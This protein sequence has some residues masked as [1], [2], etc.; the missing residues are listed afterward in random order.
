MNRFAMSFVVALVAA[1]VSGAAGAQNARIITFQD[2]VRIALE[3][4]PDV[5]QAQNAAALGKVNVSEARNQ[6]LPD[7]RFSSTGAKNYGRTFDQT[8]GAIVNQSTRSLS[9]G[10][11]SSVTVFDGFGNVANLRGARLSD[12]AGEQEL[13]RTRETV[14]FNVASQFLALIQRQEQLRVQRENLQ[15]ATA[16]E[17]QIQQYVDAGARTIADLYQ[18]QANAASARFAVVDAERTSELAKVDLME[19]LQLDPTGTYEFEAP[20]D[21]TAAAA[22]QRFELA[23]LQTRAAAQRIDL[24]AEQARVEAADQNVKVARSNRWPTVSL[25]GGY[26]SAYSSASPFDLSDQLDQRRGGS[27]SLGVSVPIFDRSVTSNATR[28]AEIQADN[29][30]LAFESLQQN[31]ALQ[32]RRAHLD[33]QSAQEQLVN[34]QAQVKSAELSLSASQDRYDAGASTLL[35]VTQARA[36]QVQAAS[37][38]VSA[39]Y[40]LQFQRTLMDYY[41]GDLDPKQLSGN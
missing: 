4:N 13:T 14:A 36:T 26:S 7:L 11:N 25:N 10:V 3:Q 34:A 5:R 30:R 28:R 31:V 40:N 21:N 19:T 32:V 9:L 6:F 35:E 39:R 33:F 24:R 41:V 2:A 18:Q 8:E 15:A 16:L 12:Q 27:V 37:A 17:Q 23:N 29:E 1:A 20:A 38:L 22:S